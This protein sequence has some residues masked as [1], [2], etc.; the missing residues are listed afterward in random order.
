MASNE[1]VNR[2]ADEV[3]IGPEHLLFSSARHERLKVAKQ[4][5]PGFEIQAILGLLPDDA[6]DFSDPIFHTFNPRYTRLT[7]EQI[8]ARLGSGIRLNPYTVNDPATIV[9]L[10]DIGVTGLITDFPQRGAR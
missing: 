6:I 10:V 1:P 3:G 5:R 4:R 7:I 2:T 8:K 9:Q